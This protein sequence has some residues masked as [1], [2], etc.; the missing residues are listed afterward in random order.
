M[1]RR[2]LDLIECPKCRRDFALTADE[3]SS[4]GDI[5]TG[6]LRCLD[7]GADYPI[8]R[9]IPRF[10]PHIRSEADLRA[11]YADSFGHQW[12]TYEWLR[13]EDEFEFYQITDLDRGDLA[14]KMVLDAG[15]GGGRFAR[16]V[17]PAC[18][19][20]VGLDFSIAVERAAE[21]CA[22]DSRAHFLQC[23][24]N[25]HPLKAGLFDLVYSH[26]VLHHTPDTRTSF[27]KLSKLSTRPAE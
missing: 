8:L 22:S 10:L 17:A 23:D 16:F 6:N 12:T 21:L 27:A 18:R 26:G 15:C 3:E 14:D 24:I 7:C 9:G 11:V 20:F 19:E 4:S 13:D 5:V 2:L 1:K 25:Q